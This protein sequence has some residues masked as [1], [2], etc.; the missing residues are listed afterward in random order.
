MK[1][2]AHVGQIGEI[3]DLEVIFGLFEKL[4]FQKCVLSKPFLSYTVGTLSII[5]FAESHAPY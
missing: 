5:G 2:V 1:S 4:T 3:I